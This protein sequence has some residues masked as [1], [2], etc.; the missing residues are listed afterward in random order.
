MSYCI[1]YLNGVVTS[2][3][4]EEVGVEFDEIKWYDSW[5]EAMADN[6]DIEKLTEARIVNREISALRRE[7]TG[8][9]YAEK[10]IEAA[11]WLSGER[12]PIFF[13]YL[14]KEAEDEG[15][16]PTEHA[17]IIMDKAEATAEAERV[18]RAR[19]RDLKSL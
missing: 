3:G 16:T 12:L 15:I 9:I 2:M 1:Q 4:T 8:S 19:K 14:I 17:R 7:K 18:R 11:R 5:K 6:P 13:M 10:R